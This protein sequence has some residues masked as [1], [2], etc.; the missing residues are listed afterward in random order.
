MLMHKWIKLDK[1]QA[2]QILTA[3]GDKCNH[4]VFTDDMTEVSFKTLPFY[5]NYKIYKLSNY[6][7]MPVFTMHFLSN[8]EEFLQ[9]NGLAN[10]IYE[11]NAKDPIHLTS[12]TLIQYLKFFFRYVQG[13]EGEVFI[14]QSPK[15]IPHFRTLPKDK[16]NEVIKNFIP[17]KTISDTD[18]EGIIHT[19]K[20]QIL[21][22]DAVIDTH[23]N[24]RE[25]GNIFFS[26]QN[27]IADKVH[28][29]K[30]I[31]PSYDVA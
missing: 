5:N 16:Q 1:K 7:T 19:A 4:E 14:I 15:D 17:V 24:M 30:N 3:L 6:A 22:G 20:A 31:Y 23:I 27:I 26:N 18:E 29:P 28:L 21:Y 12:K 9:L 11:V 8:G 13:S 10:P 2:K 25:N